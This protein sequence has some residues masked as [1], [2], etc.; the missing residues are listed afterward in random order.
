VAVVA[1]RARRET[2]IRFM[3]GRKRK[4]PERVGSVCGG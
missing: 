4:V 1:V 3:E 2:E